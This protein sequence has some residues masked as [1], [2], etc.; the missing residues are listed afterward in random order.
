VDVQQ[1]NDMETTKTAIVAQLTNQ[2]DSVSG[3]SLDEEMVNLV[4]YQKS[5]AAAARVVTMMDQLLETIIN[6]MGVTR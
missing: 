1:A 2:R 4:K 6:G 5:F 3:V